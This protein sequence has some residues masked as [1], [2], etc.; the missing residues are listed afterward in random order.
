MKKSLLLLLLFFIFFGVNA[1]QLHKNK[2]KTS[3]TYLFENVN[4]VDV[5]NNKILKNMD[6]YIEGSTI[7]G[8]EKHQESN[9]KYRKNIV[10]IPC[11]GKYIMPG[12]ID[13]HTH[14]IFK[15]ELIN[16]LA[17]GVTIVFSLG[18]PARVLD[19]KQQ[20]K[21]GTL[22]GPNIYAAQMLDA[23]SQDWG[24]IVFNKVVKSVSDVKKTITGIKKKGWDF[25]K[26]YNSLSTEVFDEIMFFAKQK[27]LPVIGHGVR[28][29]GMEYILSSGMAMVA[30]AEEYLYTVFKDSLDESKIS[31]AAA[32]TRKYGAFVCA[33]LS[34]FNTL[35]QIWGDSLKFDQL[36]K[37][38]GNREL[39]LDSFTRASWHTNNPYIH[40]HG[41][42][43]SAY[44]FL[45]K[46]TLALHKAGVP[47]VAG[48]DSPIIPGCF[49]GYSIVNELNL[50]I[51]AGLSNYQALQCATMNAGLFIQKHVNKKIK[52]GLIEKGYQADLLLL[53]E[54]PVINIH[55]LHKV[56]GVMNNGKWHSKDE[57][58]EKRK[59]IFCISE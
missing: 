33:N 53:D 55:N 46:L 47:L 49:P 34:T 42:I 24:G 11:G 27:N 22:D 57:I 6:L 12:L 48:T 58:T 18:S 30:H 9:I 19:F 7:T 26:V 45:Q 43:A 20:I 5:K 51:E 32:M 16:Y 13:C 44:I 35:S 59:H 50:L 41:S 8:I 1:Q 38:G 40:K 31:D 15:N 10:V 17:S 21:E 54:N 56:T 23:V 39:Y 25:L 36:L 2:S 4:I 29:A 3:N 37:E 14:I 52:L 28:Q